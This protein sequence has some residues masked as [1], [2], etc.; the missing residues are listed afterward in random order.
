M[1]IFFILENRF[2]KS[3]FLLLVR[4]AWNPSEIWASPMRVTAHFQFSFPF[5]LVLVNP[6]DCQFV[7]KLKYKN[8]Q[9]MA[10]IPSHKALEIY[11]EMKITTEWGQHFEVS[12]AKTVHRKDWLWRYSKRPLSSFLFEGKE[13]I[14]RLW[15]QKA[16]ELSCIAQPSPRST[17]EPWL[18]VLQGGASDFK[19]GVYPVLDEFR[20]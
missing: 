1:F 16:Q 14:S 19:C 4:Q 3:K 7:R 17:S 2:K 5:P 11:L 10:Q 6:L 20:H 12:Q 18:S 15:L 8:P 13:T 9:K